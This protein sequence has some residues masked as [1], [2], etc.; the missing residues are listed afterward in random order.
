MQTHKIPHF[1]VL[2]FEAD[3]WKH[4]RRQ[5]D[6][7]QRAGTISAADRGHLR[8]VRSPEDAVRILRHC[9]EGLCSELGKPPLHRRAARSARGRP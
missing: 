1:P 7:M 8:L 5:L 3:F 6:V 4:L 2:L 9:H